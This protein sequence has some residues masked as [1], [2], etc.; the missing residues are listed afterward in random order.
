MLRRDRQIRRQI[1]QLTDA[2]LFAMSFWAAY[3][4]RENP[5]VMAW[6]NLEPFP[7]NASFE[8]LV[9]LYFALIPVAPLILESQNFYNR[10][11]MCPRGMIFWPL[12]KGCL[13]TTTGLALAAYSFHLNVPRAVPTFFGFISFA[14]VY[15]KEESLRLAFRSK[16][17]QSQY[18]RRFI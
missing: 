1:H 15:L 16:F 12:L 13:I 17:A 5:Q 14:L 10:P 9:W 2:C 7:E 4:L 8:K 6:L 11:P 3:V 18:K